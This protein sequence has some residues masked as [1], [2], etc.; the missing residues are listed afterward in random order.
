MFRQNFA[1]LGLSDHQPMNL[2]RI[3]ENKN[4]DSMHT[5]GIKTCT[6]IPW[7]EKSLAWKLKEG[8][9]RQSMSIT[10]PQYI[11]VLVKNQKE[12]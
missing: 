9:E 7:N 2:S 5:F 11:Y 1:K 12:L 6:N 8:L 10:Q 3:E 4:S